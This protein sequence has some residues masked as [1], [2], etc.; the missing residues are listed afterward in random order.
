MKK[1]FAILSVAAL[2]A[3]GWIIG[4]GAAASATDAPVHTGY[5]SYLANDYENQKLAYVNDGNTLTAPIDTSKIPCGTWSVQID[6]VPL[7][8]TFP[9]TLNPNATPL[10]PIASDHKFSVVGTKDCTTPTPTPTVKPTHH[11]KPHHTHRATHTPVPK[12]VEHR[13]AVCGPN[14]LACTGTNNLEWAP[15][16]FGAVGLGL[17]GLLLRRRYNKK[18]PTTAV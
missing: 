12:A 11:P 15:Y 13:H 6:V 10:H 18:H 17:A 8:Q 9:V 4:G 1:I 7:S 2:L 5:Y 14:E 3:L 16:A